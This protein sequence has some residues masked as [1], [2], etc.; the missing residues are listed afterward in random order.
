MLLN[1][2]YNKYHMSSSSDSSDLSIIS[3]AIYKSQPLFVLLSL[4]TFSPVLQVLRCPLM[5]RR[6]PLLST[7]CPAICC[8]LFVVTSALSR[9]PLHG[10]IRVRRGLSSFGT[11]TSSQPS[12]SQVLLSLAVSFQFFTFSFFRSSKTS[13]CHRCLGLPTGLFPIRLQSNSF[14]VGLAWS[15]LWI[16]PSHLILCALISLY[17][18]LLLIYQS[19]CYFVF[20]VFCQV[21]PVAQSL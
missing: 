3:K 1:C 8:V 10:C 18:H 16:C 19:P 7:S 12:L 9:H 2:S 20:S 14:P 13:S 5:P 15:I 21:G 11:T 17:L 6:H 4:S